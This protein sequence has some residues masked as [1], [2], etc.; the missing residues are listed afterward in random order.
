VS[1]IFFRLAVVFR[2]VRW[3]FSSFLTNFFFIVNLYLLLLC[4]MVSWLCYY[5]F[6][7]EGYVLD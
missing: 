6:W 3:E 1:L 2:I 5:L 4:I 7:W